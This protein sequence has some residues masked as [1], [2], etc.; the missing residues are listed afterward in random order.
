MILQQ[1]EQT[2]TIL[3]LYGEFMNALGVISKGD[4]GSSYLYLEPNS[5][6]GPA[7]GLIKTG[8]FLAQA[9]VESVH[10]GACNEVSWEKDVFE[11]YPL[12]NACDQGGR[13]IGRSAPYKDSDSCF[14]DEAFM[15]CEVDG[16]MSTVALTLG[17]FEGVPPA[18]GLLANLK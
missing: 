6:S 4:I 18:L 12:S 17:I 3:Y 11:R 13:L 1:K 15:A 5:N 10:F 7:Y 14:E 16:D 8:L 9:A 2:P